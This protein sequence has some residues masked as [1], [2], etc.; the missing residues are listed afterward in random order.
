MPYEIKPDTG[1]GVLFWVDSK[2]NERGP[3]CRG[4]ITFDVGLLRWLVAQAKAGKELKVD[5]AGWNRSSRTGKQF[6]SVLAQVP[7]EPPPGGF[8]PRPAPPVQQPV[9]PPPR[10][11]QPLEDDEIPF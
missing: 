9:R 5:I 4:N 6:L 8:A 11:V 10:A 1:D 3:D 2:T 7:R